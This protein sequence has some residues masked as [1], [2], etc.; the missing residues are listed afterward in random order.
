MRKFLNALISFIL[1]VLVV[2]IVITLFIS[3]IV[4]CVWLWRNFITNGINI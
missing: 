1:A 2:F 4:A 3:L